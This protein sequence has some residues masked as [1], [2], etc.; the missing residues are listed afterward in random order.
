MAGNDFRFD[1]YQIYKQDARRS[2][3]KFRY[4]YRYG[5]PYRK[6]FNSFILF[7]PFPPASTSE[8]PVGGETS[9]FQPGEK[10]GPFYMDVKTNMLYDALLV[11]NIGVEFYVGKNWSLAGNWMY[12]WWKGHIYG[13]FHP[14]SPHRCRNPD[15]DD[16][17]WAANNH[18]PDLP[19]SSSYL[20]LVWLL[21]R[22]NYNEKKGGRQ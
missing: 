18:T 4:M 22:G 2:G 3:N 8:S 7:S 13:I 16:G 9:G 17:R 6:R 1:S 10:H 15:S 19:N 5:M 12:A 11:P 14:N 20:S 21:G